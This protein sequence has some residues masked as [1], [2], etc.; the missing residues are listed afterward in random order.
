[1]QAYRVSEKPGTKGK[2]T[3]LYFEFFQAYLLEEETYRHFKFNAGDAKAV[4]L[5]F[6]L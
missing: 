1:M 3:T 5:I 2:M 4:L 6:R